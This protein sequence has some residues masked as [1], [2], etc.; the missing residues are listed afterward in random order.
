MSTSQAL[1]EMHAVSKHYLL[2]ESRIDALKDINGAIMPGEFVAVWGPSGSGKS[3]FCNLIGLL[4]A[5]SSG[6]VSFKGQDAAALS[7]V[8]RSELRNRSIGF[9]FQS[10]NLVPV[11]SALE[12]VMLPLQIGRSPARD[13]REAALARLGEVGLSSHLAHRPSRLSG[14]QQ[15]RVAI[16]RAL[17]GSP[18][19]VVADEPTANLDSENALKVIALMRAISRSEGTAF[20]FSTHDE[21]LLERVD[22]RIT[23]CDGVV[24][25][26]RKTAAVL[27]L[28]GQ[29][30]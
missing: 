23:L 22:R 15:Q 28:R 29:S 4:D 17:V 11:L 6:R 16:A 27:P 30:C 12:N 7:D 13:A 9:V 1:I 10:F 19:L 14:G 25:D 21:R 24:M 26:D 3:T 5:P 2:G 8:E 18:A 20:V